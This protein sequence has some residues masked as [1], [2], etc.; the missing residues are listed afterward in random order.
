MLKGEDEQQNLGSLDALILQPARSW[1]ALD[2]FHN[3]KAAQM[4]N[5][6]ISQSQESGYLQ[7]TNEVILQFRKM[8][9]R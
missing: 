5:F 9:F 7:S 4:C 8:F 3:I 2:Q 6:S 1:G